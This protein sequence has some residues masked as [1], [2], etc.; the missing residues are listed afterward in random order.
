MFRTLNAKIMP[1]RHEGK[2]KSSASTGRIVALDLIRGVAILGI[3]AVNIS[4]FS[5]PS[6]GGTIP[7]LSSPV[8]QTAWAITFLLFDGKMRTL[9]A[10]IFGAGIALH[11]TR[12]EASGHNAEMLQVRRLTWLMLFGMLHYLLLWWGD[13]LFVY[14][15]CGLGALCLHRQPTRHLLVIAVAIAIALI[16]VT[17]QAINALPLI[18]AEEAVRLGIATAG[19]HRAVNDVLALHNQH[20]QSEYSLYRSGFLSIVLA[21]LQDEPFWLISMTLNSWDEILPCMLL[22]MVILRCA[23]QDAKPGSRKLLM[24]GAALM[25]MGT[26]ASAWALH[27]AWSRQ[28]PAIATYYLSGKLLLIPHLLLACGYGSILFAAAP[29]IAQSALGRRLIA[30]GRMPLT[31]YIGTSII[32]CWLFYG[33]GLGLFGSITPLQGWIVVI[34]AW[35]FMLQATESW[36]KFSNQGPLE[37]L[38]RALIGQ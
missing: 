23:M 6:I 14:A 4:G 17:I 32:M 5:A 25:A 28:F 29:S 22:G 12:M 34:I 3:L 16:A 27:W 1:D 20:A 30:C 9:L 8:D 2:R 21:K 26:V 11:C 18:Q 15:V 33:W 31:N 19:E 36:L 7:R 38:W 37:R 13:I 24:T 35:A 10:M